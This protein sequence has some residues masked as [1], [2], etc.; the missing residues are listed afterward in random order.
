MKVNTRSNSSKTLKS[1]FARL[2]R[3]ISSVFGKLN[4]V[5][6]PVVNMASSFMQIFNIRKKLIV[7]FLIL[8]ILPLSITGFFAYSDSS[9]AM[10]SKVQSYLQQIV[11]QSSNSLNAQVTKFEALTKELMG[12]DTFQN[13]LLQYITG[14][15]SIKTDT[16]GTIIQMLSNKFMQLDYID[17]Y[18]IYLN[19]DTADPSFHANLGTSTSEGQKI[20]KEVANDNKPVQWK[21]MNMV[22]NSGND[23]GI[24][25]GTAKDLRSSITG[26]SVG[27]VILMPKNNYLDSVFSNLDIGSYSDGKKFPIFVIDSMGT[28][29]SSADEELGVGV[30]NEFTTNL[31]KEIVNVHNNAINEKSTNLTMDYNF[32]GVSSLVIF[33]PVA[34]T[35]WFM[36]SAVSYEYLNAASKDIGI[37]IIIIAI[38]CLFFALIISYILSNSISRPLNLL[39]SNMAK[40]KKG[41][42]NVNVKST[43]K[44][45]IASVCNNFDEMLSNISTLIKKVQ[46]TSNIVLGSADRISSLADQSSSISQ[47]IAY[48]IQ[49][50]ATGA[51]SQSEHIL[52]GVNNLNNLSSEI[53]HVDMNMTDVTSVLSK[54]NELSLI[55]NSAV[56]ELNLKARDTSHATHLIIEDIKHLSN[57]IKDI[58]KITKVISGIAEQTNLLSL[59]ASIEASKAGES[60]RGFAVVASEVKKLANQSKEAS[61]LISNII[62]KVQTKTENTVEAANKTQIIINDEIRAVE[63]ADTIFKTIFASME[64]IVVSMANMENSVKSMLSSKELCVDSIENVSIVADQSAAT[65]QEISASTQ[66]QM[67]FSEDLSIHAKKLKLLAEEMNES[68]SQFTIKQS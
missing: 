25:I 53:N 52:E 14:D 10:E 57:E 39:E 36:V 33:S 41:L 31:S 38:I 30:N 42:L 48:T 56:N 32:N 44:D 19:G 61:I 22:D 68:I 40:A 37:K 15:S 55:A 60:G 63:E 9:S 66:E 13:T 45:E 43:G 20:F 24:Q 4:Q 50:I 2:T 54:T 21:L 28:I 6:A 18:S 5:L 11:N 12:D 47:Q 1:S 49:E 26:D 27:A 59:N 16:S 51:S 46:D 17:F 29:I 34:N 58:K 67:T 3:V 64:H 62:S 23:I 8:S 35:D 7:S 65:T